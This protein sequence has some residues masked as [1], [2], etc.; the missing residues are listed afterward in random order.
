MINIASTISSDDI[1]CT[2]YFY[3]QR[4]QFW[5]TFYLSF[6]WTISQG[7]SCERT[8]VRWRMYYSTKCTY[9]LGKFFTFLLHASLLNDVIAQRMHSIT[10]NSVWS[11][12][13]VIFVFIQ[14]D[15]HLA[16]RRC[17]YPWKNDFKLD[18]TL[19]WVYNFFCCNVSTANVTISDTVPAPLTFTW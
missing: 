5:I 2:R 7:I 19:K 15:G 8:F 14:F 17:E 13:L 16:S 4:I 3:A 9:V 11:L 1:A 6:L 10:N 12:F 18:G